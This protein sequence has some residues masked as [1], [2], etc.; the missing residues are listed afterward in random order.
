MR[1]TY[2][3]L[4]EFKKSYRASHWYISLVL[5]VFGFVMNTTS[6]VVLAKINPKP[7]STNIIIA[8]LTLAN[9][10]VNAEYISYSLGNLIYSRQPNERVLTYAWA[11]YVLFH[12]YS[13]QVRA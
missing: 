5:C 1:S 3:D 7:T 9:N 11:S 2:C 10:V 6:I 12:M 13:C 8:S 4:T